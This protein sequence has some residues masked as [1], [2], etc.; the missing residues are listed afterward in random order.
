MMFS[1]TV[2]DHDPRV[3]ADAV[4]SCRRKALSVA[5]GRRIQASRAC[6][7]DSLAAYTYG[8][9]NQ[10][11][12]RVRTRNEADSEPGYFRDRMV[13]IVRGRPGKGSHRLENKCDGRV[14][15]NQ[16]NG[17]FAGAMEEEKSGD[18]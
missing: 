14:A 10:A 17:L 12:S 7:T 18:A 6:S 11:G 13:E 5:R 1:R 4:A 16:S 8:D 9:S 3:P 2:V 15:W